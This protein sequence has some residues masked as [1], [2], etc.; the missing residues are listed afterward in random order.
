MKG[1]T[2]RQY[3]ILCDHMEVYRFMTEI[4]ERDWRNGPA[5]PFHEYALSSSWMDKD[6]THLSRLWYDGDTIVGYCFTEDP[7]TD[8]YF[9]LRPSYEELADEMIRY[10]RDNMPD[11][12]RL[13]DLDSQQRIILFEGQ[14]ELIK[15]VKFL[16][17]EQIRSWVDFDL[18][19]DK[20][21]DFKLPDGFR[22][23]EPGEMDITKVAKCCYKGFDHEQED[24]P[25]DG[26][27]EHHRHLMQAPHATYDKALAVVNGEGEYVC[28]AGMWWTPENSL[29]YMEPLCTIPECRRMGLA[30]AALCEL[31]KRMKRVGAT[32]MTGGGDP[33]YKAIGF[34]PTQAKTAWVLTEGNTKQL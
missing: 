7:V 23:T 21:I 4:Y 16:G 33:F 11:R 8:I 13:P 18:S 3:R 12:S 19:L 5:A 27:A 24:G 20:D 17:Y 10:A 25:W 6:Y 28:F 32:H 31:S 1:I 14:S 26:D 2:T 29:A 34:E 22:F 30:A 9:C 15:T